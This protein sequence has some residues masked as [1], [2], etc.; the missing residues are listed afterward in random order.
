MRSGGETETVDNKI[1]NIE[2]QVNTIL[3][4]L[5]EKGFKER[6]DALKVMKKLFSNKFMLESLLEK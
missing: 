4:G 6:E 3:D 2:S 1:E 5:L